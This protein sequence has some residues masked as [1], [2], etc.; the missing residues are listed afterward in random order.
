MKNKKR[1]LYLHAGAEMYGADKIL[2]EIV[3][4]L[5]KSKFEPLVILPTHGMLEDEMIRN[6]I[7]VHI[8][9]YPIL[10]RKFFTP[11]GCIKYLFKYIKYGHKLSRFVKSHNIDLVHVNTS[12]VLE[13]IYLKTFLRIPILWH[14]HEIIL[15]PKIVYKVTSWLI[16]RYADKIVTVSKATENRLLQSNSVSKDKIETIYNGIDASRVQFE[17]KYLLKEKLGIPADNIII[18]MVGRINSWKGQSN[19]IDAVSK[20]IEK[21][22][23]VHAVLVGG[24]F[25]GEEWRI[26][27][28]DK[29]IQKTKV[30][31][32]IHRIGFNS[33]IGQVY[34]AMDIFVM[35]S[36]R[37]DPFPTVVLEAMANSLPVIAFNHGGVVEMLPEKSFKDTLVKVGDNEKLAE[38]INVLVN[39]KA[40]R[41]SIG[42]KA[43]NRQSEKFDERKFVEYFQSKY[44]EVLEVK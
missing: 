29:L 36:T 3:T 11:L 1:I 10:R 21:N 33:E 35:P 38:K 22:N 44:N 4:R 26:E 24:V 39:D 27:N 32:K 31:E 19:F 16:G 13:G 7:N 17:N 28:I 18:G 43:K 42:E 6:G 9:N 34:A 8:L 41:L 30:P 5:D 25:E 2:L 20:V 14:I 37:P 23:N 12:A 15:R 40:K